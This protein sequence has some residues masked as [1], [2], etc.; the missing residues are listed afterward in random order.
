MTRRRQQRLEELEELRRNST[1]M[2][3]D[4]HTN[5]IRYALFSWR[6]WLRKW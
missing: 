1:P 6:L 2:P 5:P 4:T 3:P